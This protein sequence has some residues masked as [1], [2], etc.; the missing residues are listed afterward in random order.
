V[1][2]VAGRTP[3]LIAASVVLMALIGFSRIHDRQ[4]QG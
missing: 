2:A 4:L 3:R 1:S